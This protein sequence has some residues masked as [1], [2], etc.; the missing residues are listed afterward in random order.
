[1]PHPT[2]LLST[3]SYH[4]KS[5]CPNLQAPHHTPANRL[6]R[7]VATNGTLL[8]LSALLWSLPEIASLKHFEEKGQSTERCNLLIHILYVYVFEHLHLFYFDV[9]MAN[10]C[11]TAVYGL[12][13]YVGH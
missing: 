11:H 7:L 13:F 12:G 3:Q 8:R 2:F 9:K 10:I 5:R 1:M 6:P 4:T